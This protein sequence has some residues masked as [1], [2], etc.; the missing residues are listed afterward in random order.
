M[1][2]SILRT[3]HFGLLEGRQRPE[4]TRDLYLIAGITC[5]L[6]AKASHD[7]G[8]A[9]D[10]MTQ[11]RTGYACADNAGHNGLRPGSVG[12]SH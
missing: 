12:C 8:A 9:H 3:A 6:M 10:A 11:A 4:Q 5:G 1:I 7:L 2:W